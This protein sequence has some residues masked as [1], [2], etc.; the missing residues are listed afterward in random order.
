MVRVN[1]THGYDGD[2]DLSLISPTGTTVDLT[3]DNGGSGDNYTNTFFNDSCSASISSTTSLAP[4]SACY[5]PEQAALDAQRSGGQRK[6]GAEDRGRRWARGGHARRLAAR[7]LR[8]V[9]C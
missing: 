2:V 4:Y 6:L 3:S 7:G 9:T 1:I 8:A 5:Q